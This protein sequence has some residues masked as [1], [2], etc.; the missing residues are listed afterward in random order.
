MVERRPRER[1]SLRAKAGRAAV[2][3]GGWLRT[4]A[5]CCRIDARRPAS[6]L[7]AAAA[8]LAAAA[9]SCSELPGTAAASCV[10]AAMLAGAMAAV[11]AIGDPPRSGCGEPTVWA[12]S[13][14]VW[15]VM[16]TLVSGGI[17]L[18]FGRP[19]EVRPAVPIVMTVTAT[20]TAIAIGCGCRR[21]GSAA[22]AA[23]VALGMA[24]AAATA[25]AC[26]P[27][28]PLPAA[29]VA[30]LA[31]GMLGQAVVDRHGGAMLIAAAARDLLPASGALG[32]GGLTAAAMLASL[33]GM[34]GWLFLTP[35]HASR[36][37]ALAVGWFVAA[38][39][40]QA[41]LAFG[42][43]GEAASRMLLA[44]AA[45]GSRRGRVGRAGQ[46]WLQRH[47]WNTVA[48]YAAILGWPPLVAA[49]LAAD[50]PL[51]WERCTVA[52]TV[53][54][55]GLGL[56]ATAAAGIALGWRRD[57][58]QGICLL[59]A[60]LGIVACLAV[61]GPKRGRDTA[62]HRAG[63]MLSI[64]GFPARLPHP[65]SLPP[66]LPSTRGVESCQEPRSPSP[67]GRLVMTHAPERSSPRVPP[68]CTAATVP[69]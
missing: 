6:W 18:L 41:V 32:G 68:P 2:A 25:A 63:M 40:P 9:L 3:G 17:C 53:A 20:A 24:A 52:L 60:M 21:G 29:I 5:V 66:G 51:A 27:A 56:A 42:S 34:V 35:Q 31:A 39:V 33:A 49:A 22:D 54:A 69:V 45:G 7:G 1:S 48:A 61:H 19:W 14:A 10:A 43:R 57:T 11:A 28:W 59:L 64:P 62:D 30:W 44:T 12:A 23:T 67:A 8:A 16:G 36:Y 4:F 58:V 65:R 47:A 13:R 55:W 15:P 46:S 50:G 26:V 37:V 38:A